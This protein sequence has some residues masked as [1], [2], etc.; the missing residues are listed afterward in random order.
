MVS[1]EKANDEIYPKKYVFS[2][3]VYGKVNSYTN[4]GDI[5]EP[6]KIYSFLE[7]FRRNTWLYG[8]T[9][10]ILLS[11][12]LLNIYEEEPANIPF[13]LDDEIELLSNSKAKITSND[14]VI[15][16]DIIRK[17][18][19]LYFQSS[20]IILGSRYID[21]P[22]NRPY[23]MKPFYIWDK[24]LKYSPLYIDTV[25]ISSGTGVSIRYDIKPCIYAVEKK[26]E[27]HISY[28]CYVE[29]TMAL[30]KVG[31]DGEYSYYSAYHAAV[32]NVQNDFSQDYLHLYRHDSNLKKDTIVYKTNT[33]IF[34]KK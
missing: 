8:S 31:V 22:D 13:K 32:Q 3:I 18:G 16:F 27:I 24:K 1:C 30:I 25:E 10:Y 6:D 17:N 14:T 2:H 28:T 26:D 20:D 34:K 12:S 9:G 4:S 21:E 7:N 29:K 15:Y 33:I 23:Y 19:V 11:G 5:N